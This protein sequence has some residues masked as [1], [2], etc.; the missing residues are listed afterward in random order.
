MRIRLPE[1]PGS[2]STDG[3]AVSSPGLRPPPPA[4]PDYAWWTGSSGSGFDLVAHDACIIE[5]LRQ[6]P[7]AVLG[8]WQTRRLRALLGYLVAERPRWRDRLRGRHDWRLDELPI[9]SRSQLARMLADEPPTAP[10]S[11]GP[12]V[13]D[14]TTGTTGEALHFAVT[15]LA[16]RMQHAHFWAEHRRCGRDLWRTFASISGRNPDYIGAHVALP[17]RPWHGQP[18]GWL[19]RVGPHAVDDHAHWLAQQRPAYL[20]L[21]GGLWQGILGAIERGRAPA[22]EGLLQVMTY[23]S[24][25][26]AGD[27]ARTRRLTGAL[28]I[29]GYSAQECGPIAQQSLDEDG[30]EV[31]MSH[32]IVEVVDDR[33]RACR[34]GQLGRVLVTGLHNWATPL[35][36]YDLGDMALAGRPSPSGLGFATLERIEGRVLNVIRLPSGARQLL[37]FRTEDLLQQMP[38]AEF[39][40]RQTDACTLCFEYVAAGAQPPPL[41]AQQRL[42]RHV[43]SRYPGMRVELRAVERIDWPANGK[44]MPFEALPESS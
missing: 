29:D 44:R 32:V 18:G 11:H 12:L 4:L 31:A 39:R 6:A 38:F 5:M 36:R 16:A 10:A 27:R 22:P 25:L 42:A 26:D 43:E 20:T 1:P 23:G 19:R 14:H 2:R 24:Q 41:P 8:D 9:L 13:S 30:Y 17:G 15:G 33:G 21:V 35:L 28:L 37:A 34:P 40:L 3:E 7:P